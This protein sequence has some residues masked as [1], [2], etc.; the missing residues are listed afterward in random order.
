MPRTARFVLPGVPHHVTQRGNR[1][2]KVFFTDVDY[3]TYLKWL[4]EYAALRGVEVLAYCLMSNHV[5]LV[6]VPAHRDSLS[7]ALKQLHMRYAQ[8]LNRRRDWKGH[9]W[10]GRF[11]ASPLDERHFWT[12]LRYVERNP[13]RA[14]MVRRAEDYPWSSARARCGL[15]QDPVLSANGQWDRQLRGIGDWS[16][17]LAAGEEPALIDELRTQTRKGL[18]CGSSEFVASLEAS[19]GRVLRP[20]PRG[21]PRPRRQTA[22]TRKMGN[23]PI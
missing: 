7:R 17:W 16:A 15:R 23:V 21:R 6:V 19:T 11:F 5:H 20:R 10:Q 1:R 2:G 12:A 4:R 13:V 22:Q 14:G 3:R 8:N 9:L 18:P